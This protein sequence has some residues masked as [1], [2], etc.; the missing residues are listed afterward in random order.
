MLA[1]GVWN[2][3]ACMYV[4]IIEQVCVRKPYICMSYV[5]R[6]VDLHNQLNDANKRNDKLRE[7]LMQT[8]REFE[9]KWKDHINEKD[10]RFNT[11]YIC[12]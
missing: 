12:T 5:C 8:E 1:T 10:K 6:I 2:L 9:N 7:Q 3:L 11:S 4:C